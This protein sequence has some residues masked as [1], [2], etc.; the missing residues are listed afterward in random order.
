MFLSPGVTGDPLKNVKAPVAVSGLTFKRCRP[1]EIAKR[2]AAEA[3]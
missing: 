1:H 3:W 2:A